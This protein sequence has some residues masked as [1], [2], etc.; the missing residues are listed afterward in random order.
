MFYAVFTNAT[1]QLILAPSGV[2]L[3]SQLKFVVIGVRLAIVE[4]RILAAFVSGDHVN[5]IIVSRFRAN[6]SGALTRFRCQRSCFHSK[7]MTL[8]E[9]S[10]AG[11]RSRRLEIKKKFVTKVLVGV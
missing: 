2:P 5:I 7:A 9:V 3:A 4:L 6:A 10:K 11:S 1:I 8:R